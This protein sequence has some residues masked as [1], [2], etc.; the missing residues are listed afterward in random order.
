MKKEKP[1]ELNRR[2]K[3]VSKYL[4]A[5]SLE[6]ILKYIGIT[7]KEANIR[8]RY[9]EVGTLYATQSGISKDILKHIQGGVWDDESNE[10]FKEGQEVDFTD[11]PGIV[12]RT[13]DH[14][15]YVIVG[16]TRANHVYKQEGLRGGVPMIKINHP[17]ARTYVNKLIGDLA[18]ILGVQVQKRVYELKPTR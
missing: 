8:V 9:Y 18:G 5:T 16:H 1:S 15:N 12:V 7:E 10:F 3:I 17:K 2:N 14:K 11:E 13:E 6:S 4:G